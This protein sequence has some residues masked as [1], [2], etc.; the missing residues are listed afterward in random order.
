MSTEGMRFGRP[1]AKGDNGLDKYLEIAR[2]ET[3]AAAKALIKEDIQDTKKE[4]AMLEQFNT[5]V[6]EKG[7][8]EVPELAEDMLQFFPQE[9]QEVFRE[10]MKETPSILGKEEKKNKQKVLESYTSPEILEILKPYKNEGITIRAM[11]KEN[12]GITLSDEEL[13]IIMD[14]L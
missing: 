8:Q 9:V 2:T 14:A 6:R 7:T 12:Y 1:S 13:N 5:A 11:Y 10:R 4:A 3:V